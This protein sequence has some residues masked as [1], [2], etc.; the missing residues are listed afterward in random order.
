ML[1]ILGRF[2]QFERE[3][4]K[5]RIQAGLQRARRQSQRLGRRRQRIAPEALQRV[6]GLSVREAA[7][8]LGVPASR[9]YRARERVTQP[10]PNC[11]SPGDDLGHTVP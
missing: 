7:K 11:V 2:A 5:E 6:Q 8:A 10:S 3:R 1:G 4:I 9:V